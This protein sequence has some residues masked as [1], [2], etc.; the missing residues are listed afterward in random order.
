MI[1]E[2]LGLSCVLFD[3]V[4]VIILC[5]GFFCELEEKCLIFAALC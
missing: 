5:L 3:S 2:E 1:F 4:F